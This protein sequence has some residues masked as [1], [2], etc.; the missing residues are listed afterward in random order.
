[1]ATSARNWKK[2]SNFE[3]ELPSGNTCL[4]KKPGMEKLLAA[5]ILP[6]ALT[7]LAVEAVTKASGPKAPQDHK[8]K[9]D[10]EENEL[11]PEIMKKFLEKE[12]ALEE[13][14][15][16]FDRVTAMCVVAPKVRLHFTQRLDDSGKAVK[17]DAGRY[18][19]DDI[20]EEERISDEVPPTLDDGSPNP[21]YS[22]NP[23]LYT[24]EID[25]KDKEFI[26]NFATGGDEKMSTFPDAGDD[27]ADVQSGE[28]VRVQG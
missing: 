2:P 21:L 8:K 4:V 1:M 12:G 16:S 11:D 18:V 3:I 20:P 14:F 22:E 26:F 17:D 27:V 9:K 23:P 28:D 25:G 10:E 7:P 24:D 19:Y 15:M 13:I 6:D 5:G